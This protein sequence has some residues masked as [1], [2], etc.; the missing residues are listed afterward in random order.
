MV[1]GVS[2]V[3]NDLKCRCSLG[4]IM[5]SGLIRMATES[6]CLDKIKRSRVVM[7]KI[8]EGTQLDTPPNEQ[9]IMLCSAFGSNCVPFFVFGV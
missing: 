4:I 6:V 3:I 5:R 9:N 7:T 1:Y 8:H 2:V